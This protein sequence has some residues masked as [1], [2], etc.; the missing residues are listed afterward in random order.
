MSR[1]PDLLKVGPFLGF[2]ALDAAMQSGVAFS[3]GGAR[4]SLNIQSRVSQHLSVYDVRPVNMRIRC[5]PGGLLVMYGTE[6]GDFVALTFNLEAARPIAHERL[7]TGEIQGGAYFDGAR[8]DI[9]ANEPIDLSLDFDVATHAFSFEVGVFYLVDGVKFVQVVRPANGPFLVTPDDCPDPDVR[10]TLTESELAQ[11][12]KH[13]FR[14]IRRRDNGQENY[15][16]RAVPPDQYTDKC[17]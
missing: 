15:V 8:V 17:D 9:P 10:S 1:Y 13:R 4:I 6:G 7:P 12:K 14:E 5:A 11:L 3:H 16:V 2:D